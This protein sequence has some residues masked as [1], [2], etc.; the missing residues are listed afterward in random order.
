MADNR[1]RFAIDADAELSPIEREFVRSFITQ[2]AERAP[3]E[4]LRTV[5]TL[6]KGGEVRAEEA[7]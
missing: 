1:L 6:R 4:A 5:E 7:A 3:K 2:R